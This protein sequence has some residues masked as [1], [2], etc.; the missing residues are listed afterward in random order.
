MDGERP[1]N[2]ISLLEGESSCLEGDLKVKK[3]SPCLSYVSSLPPPPLPAPLRCSSHVDVRGR[4]GGHPQCEEGRH[5]VI[6]E[7][8]EGERE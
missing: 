8:A 4:A 6:R 1:W 2:G 3:P 5:Q 7:A